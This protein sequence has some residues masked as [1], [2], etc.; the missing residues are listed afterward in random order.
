MH[1]TLNKTHSLAVSDTL[2]TLKCFENVIGKQPLPLDTTE[3]IFFIQHK[4]IN[5]KEPCGILEVGR[6]DMLL[7]VIKM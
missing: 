4:P 2:Q 7:V 6:G 1:N 5:K 3:Q